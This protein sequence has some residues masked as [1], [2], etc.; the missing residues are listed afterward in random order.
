MSK[1]VLVT[2]GGTGGHVFPAI[3]LAKQ[4]I[5]ANYEV[6]F[7]GG[8][9]S[10]NRYFDQTS[11]PYQ[12]VACGSVKRMDRICKGIWQSR[13]IIKTFQP[14]AVVGFGSYYTFPTLIAAKLT[15][16]PFILHEANSIPGRVNRLLAPYAAITGVHFEETL[17]LLKGKSAVVGMP[18][19]EG[20]QPDPREKQK[21]KEH[22]GLDSTK[23]TLLVFGGSQGAEA[24]NCY[25][26]R[27][28]AKDLE[29]LHFTGTDAS[30][31]VKKKMYA[32]LGVF[33]VVK[34]FEH[35]MDLAWQAA[36]MM[37]S[38]AGAGTCAEMLAFEV[39]GI[40]IPFPGAMDHHQDKNADA[41]MRLG[42]AVKV[43]EPELTEE[44][45]T[46]EI[47]RVNSELEKM[48]EAMR[49]HK[50]KMPTQDL[51]ALVREV[52]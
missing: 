37:V 20:F 52:I 15:S 19:R 35:R 16:V 29:V 7:V 39:P 30:A 31:E 50:K 21:A 12:E 38:R 34:G 41:M 11:L 36:D 46:K 6:L 43:L 3:A 33:A 25:F 24:I 18:L 17:Q 14:D 23:R 2:V 42:G 44:R 13:C 48:R 45:L 8:K 22:F 4:L 1:R 9:L 40:L 47:G 28:V 26:P 32:E 5:N 27:V 51:C 10:T 49:T